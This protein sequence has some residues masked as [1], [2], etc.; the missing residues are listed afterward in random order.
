MRVESLRGDSFLQGGSL[1]RLYDK[2]CS[3]SICRRGFMLVHRLRE[4]VIQILCK[5]VNAGAQVA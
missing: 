3:H 1:H 4:R 5:G 2:L